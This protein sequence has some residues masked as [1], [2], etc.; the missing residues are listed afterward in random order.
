MNVS[1]PEPIPADILVIDD[2]PENLRLLATILVKEGYNVRKALNGS[3][4]LTAVQT[5]PPD[6]ILLDI[7]MPDMDGYEVCHRLKADPQTAKIPIIFLSALSEGLDKAK[8]FE[9][10]GADYISK[11]FQVQEVLARVQNQ[12]ALR[13]AELQNEA[14]K[15]QLEARVK[16]RTSQLEVANQELQQQV[17]ERQQLQ[18]ELL[19][20]ALHDGLTGLPNRALFMER[21]AQALQQAKPQDAAEPTQQ[22]AVLFLDCDRF[23]V[24]NDSLGHLV[25]DELLVAIARRLE[26]CL[27]P[28]HTLSRLGGDEFAVL[29]TG[30]ANLQDA[31]Q[32]AEQILTALA[33]PF[34]LTRHEVFINASIGITLYQPEYEQP[35]HLLRDADTAM[36][37]A[38]ALGRGQYQVFDPM[39]HTRALQLLHLETD[40]RR[41]IQQQEFVVHY[42][43]IVS[44]HNHQLIGFEAL[45][46][47]Q[48]PQHGLLSPAVFIP[49]AEETGLIAQIG[50]WVL[51][52]A[53][54]QLCRWQQ[55]SSPNLDLSI[56]VNLSARQVAQLDLVEQ[57]D[58]ILIDTQVNPQALKLEITE[59]V[60]MENPQF[61]S[62]MFQ[63][64]RERQIQLSIDDFGTGYSSLSYLHSFP[65]N[66]LKIDRSFVQRMTGS[67]EG[68]GLVPLIINIAHSLGLTVVAEG[69]E[70]TQQLAQLKTL[71]C[72]LG[73]G[74][75]FSKPLTA[76]QATELLVGSLPWLDLNLNSVPLAQ[77]IW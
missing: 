63:E 17:Y 37:R 47:W 74:Y 54:Q 14:L 19:R 65:L 59:S 9:T 76:E 51:R 30:I 8:A 50:D 77:I 57:I 21:L 11:P 68:V 56:S 29:L 49:I 4:A 6:L 36:Y 53:C 67:A 25:G 20:M 48:H 34:Q 18:A 69:I 27:S 60:I 46:R 12:L 26:Q 22:F 45:V 13:S 43:P 32:V 31:I 72:D 55:G 15:T 5:V 75:L 70:T 38:K 35:E 64:L 33:Q 44:L 42:Q 66:I 73:Q 7:M 23:K 61:A 28:N 2:I 62:V 10:G 41:A 71:N 24:V 39:M 3:M 52:E 1:Q 16:E 58:Q 40:L